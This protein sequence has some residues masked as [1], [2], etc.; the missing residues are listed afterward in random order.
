MI[1]GIKKLTAKLQ[2]GVFKLPVFHEGHVGRIRTRPSNNVFTRIA[3][4]SWLIDSK[5]RAI[6]I[7]VKPLRFTALMHFP[8]YARNDVGTVSALKSS[9]VVVSIPSNDAE[10]IP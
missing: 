8:G 9:G 4:G 1:E 5:G 2:I 3:K 6:E 7:V 10:W